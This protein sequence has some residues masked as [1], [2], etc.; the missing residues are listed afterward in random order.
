MTTLAEGRRSE[1]RTSRGS[2]PGERKQ[3]LFKS[4]VNELFKMPKW[5]TAH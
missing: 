4:Y 5:F 2:A 1:S 3:N